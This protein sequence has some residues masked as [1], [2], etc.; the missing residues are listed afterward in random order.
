MSR[1]QFRR[2]VNICAAVIIV[3]VLLL[4]HSRLTIQILAGITLAAGLAGLGYALFQY[5]TTQAKKSRDRR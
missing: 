2:I 5:E 4:E 3:S 1:L